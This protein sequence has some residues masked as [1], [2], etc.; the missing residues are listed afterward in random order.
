M[1]PNV[2]RLSVLPNGLFGGITFQ[3]WGRN[4][5]RWGIGAQ[6][7]RLRMQSITLQELRQLGVTEEQ[8]WRHEIFT[9]KSQRETQ[10][11]LLP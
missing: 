11:T 9:P 8:G 2:P 7:A 1:N 3:G 10:V 4:I 6:G 5:I